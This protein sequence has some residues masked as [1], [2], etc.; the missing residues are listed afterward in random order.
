MDRRD[1]SVFSAGVEAAIRR[2]RASGLWEAILIYTTF[3][4]WSPPVS[5]CPEYRC[6]SVY[7]VPPNADTPFLSNYRSGSLMQKRNAVIITAAA[8]IALAGL[9]LVSMP[10]GTAGALPLDT[11]T[12]PDGFSIGIYAAG[13]PGARPMALSETVTP[14]VGSGGGGKVETLPPK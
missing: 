11:V 8:V 1:Y 3:L 5:G 7:E 12:L 4:H 9:V 14:F 10:T 13:V 6:R 2:A